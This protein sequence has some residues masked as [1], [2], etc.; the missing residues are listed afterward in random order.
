VSL[1]IRDRREITEMTERREGGRLGSGL[2]EGRGEFFCILWCSL[3]HQ[4]FLYPDLVL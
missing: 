3:S 1:W 4:R 2:Q